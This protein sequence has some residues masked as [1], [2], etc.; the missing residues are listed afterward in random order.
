[1]LCSWQASYDICDYNMLS[2]HLKPFRATLSNRNIH[3]YIKIPPVILNILGVTLNKVKNL[4][5]PD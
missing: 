4:T 2:L 5:K 3:E 1:M